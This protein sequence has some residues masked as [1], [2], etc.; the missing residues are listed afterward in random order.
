MDVLERVSGS[1][2]RNVNLLK[3]DLTTENQGF[4][5]SKLL[6]QRKG[7]RKENKSPVAKQRETACQ[8]GP[9]FGVHF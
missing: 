2:S 9:Q 8:S 3:L 7:S 6:I 1:N 4:S 5:G